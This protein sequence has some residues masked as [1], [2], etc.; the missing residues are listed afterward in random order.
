LWPE[1]SDC[2][3]GRSLASLSTCHGIRFGAVFTA[4]TRQSTA[5]F[6]LHGEVDDCLAGAGGARSA[7]EGRGVETVP[8]FWATADVFP[9]WIRGE[10]SDSSESEVSL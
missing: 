7:P 6:E 3:T 2:N 1:K 4:E 5:T 10:R 8:N 9:L